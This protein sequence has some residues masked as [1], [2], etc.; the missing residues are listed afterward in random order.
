MPEVQTD[1]DLQAPV[2]A[3][4]EIEID[5]PPESVWAVLTDFDRW[6]EWNTDV[7]SMSFSGPV[8]VGSQFRWRAG[9]GTIASTIVQVESPRRIVWLGKTL[10][11]KAVHAWTLEPRAGGTLVRT[12]ESYDG[13][14][15]RLFRGPL[16]K[17]LDTSLER[18]LGFLKAEVEKPMREV[19]E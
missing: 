17:T 1:I 14:V 15:A 9:P 2:V 7:K 12:E 11:I 13:L 8:T 5:S 6:P 16:Q 4:T 3:R 19:G 18:G 10:G